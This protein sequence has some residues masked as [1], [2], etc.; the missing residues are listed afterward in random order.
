M[1]LNVRKVS[2]LAGGQTRY[3]WY[4]DVSLDCLSFEVFTPLKCGKG[5]ERR[6][7]GSRCS[8][9][10]PPP[11][12]PHTLVRPT[13]RRS[14]PQPPSACAPPLACGHGCTRGVLGHLDECCCSLISSLSLTG[15]WYNKQLNLGMYHFLAG[16]GHSSKSIGD[17]VQKFGTVTKRHGCCNAVVRLVSDV[18]SVDEAIPTATGA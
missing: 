1:Y 16:F 15:I 7:P 11:A 5:K 2:T 8:P 9:P 6:A 13:T 17:K 14:T 3:Y 10:P 12:Q 18:A 4:S